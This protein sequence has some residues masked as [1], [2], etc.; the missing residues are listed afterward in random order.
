MARPSE[1]PLV[2]VEERLEG[3]H[4]RLLIFLSVATF[5]EGYDFYAI[6]QV[7]PALRAEMGLPRE[8]SAYLIAFVNIGAVLAFLLV[9]AADRYGR[10]RMLQITIAGYT[11]CTFLSGLAPEIYSFGVAQLIARIFLLAEWAIS[12]VMIAE[13]FPARHRGTIIGV[14]QGCSTLGSIVCVVVVPLL[15]ESG[16]GWRN[17]YFIAVAPLVILAFSRRNL[18]ETKRFDAADDDTDRSLFAIWRTPYR[19]RLLRV[20][21]IWFVT[22][23]PTQNAIALWKDYAVSDLGLAESEAGG[24][25]F[26]ATPIAIPFVFLSGR[27]LDV[28]GRRR[29][30]AIIFGIGA[31]GIAGC[32]T[33]TSKAGLIGAMV[34]GIFTATAYLPVLNSYTTELFPTELRG[35]AFAW[36]NNILGRIGYVLS[37]LAV[38]LM[39]EQV[40]GFRLPVLS[41]VPFLLVGI[42]MIYAFLPETKGKPL[43]ETS[44]LAP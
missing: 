12:M 18:R 28:V 14:V 5:F 6:T 29:G 30:A 2:P 35:A 42:V 40:G 31:L 9:R 41:T 36:A 37:P 19:K 17:V 3:Y 10:S 34:F 11:I 44:A 8:A 22:Y 4:W 24:V 43:E 32:Y 20:A 27:L 26:L 16:W 21:A 39:V 15:V 13:E 23:I 1:R 25:I 33:L 7:L 38:G